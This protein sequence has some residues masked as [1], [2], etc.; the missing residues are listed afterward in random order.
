MTHIEAKSLE[1]WLRYNLKCNLDLTQYWHHKCLFS[2]Q[3]Y[4]SHIYQWILLHYGSLRNY[5]N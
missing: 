2:I 3:W 1:K 5:H 4:L